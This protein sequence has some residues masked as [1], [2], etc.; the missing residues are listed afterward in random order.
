MNAYER[1]QHRLRGEPVD[2]APNFDIIMTFGAKYIGRPLSEYYKDWRVL[3][4]ANLA[5]VEH[6]Q[7]DI[8]QAI[9]DPFRETADFGAE[10]EF[11]EDDLP[12]SLVPL[13]QD[14]GD[15]AKLKTPDPATGRRMSDRLEAIRYFRSQVGGQVPIMGW[16]EGAFAESADLRGI[17][18]L[19]TDTIENPRFVHDLLERCVAVEI[20]FAQ[21]QIAAGADIV[22]L[23]DAAAS[24]INPRMYQEFALP[25]QQRIFAAIRAAGGVGRLHICGQSTHLLPLL[26]QSGADIIDVDWM[27]DY[28]KAAQVYGEHGVAACGNFDPVAVMLQGTPEKVRAAAQACLQLGGARSFSAAG[29]EIPLATP[30]ANLRAHTP[31][32]AAAAGN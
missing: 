7:I 1:F 18:S 28:G 8:V 6:F 21:A 12:L 14:Y 32:L 20:A 2:R 5:M 17:Q 16:V 24:L 9:S 3:C 26:A 11:P 22:G 10:I 13:L 4:E 15:L 19:M 25:Y 30:H 27:V 31:A 23:G 29:C